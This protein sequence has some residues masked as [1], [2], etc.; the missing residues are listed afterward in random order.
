MSFFLVKRK[1]FD[2][3]IGMKIIV[4]HKAPDLDAISSSWIIKKFLP[5]WEDARLE[6]VYAG[7]KLEGNYTKT[8]GA[9]EEIDGEEVIH[10]DTGLTPLD[11]HQTQDMN[12]C[13]ASLALDFV[14]E[15]NPDLL[16]H[17][18][19]PE[20]LRRLVDLIVDTDHFQDVYYPDSDS[21][22]YDLTI[23]SIIDGFKMEYPQD[24]MACA[25]F[26]MECLDKLLLVFESRVATE[27]DLKEHAISFDTK[28]GKGMAIES[29]FDEV[30]KLAQIQGYA[31]VVRKDPNE[32]FIRIKSRPAPREK[33]FATDSELKEARIDLTPV[34]EEIKKQDKTGTWFL[35]VSKKMLLN[36][37]SKNP[38]SVASPL[39]LEQI[40]EILKKTLV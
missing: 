11:H 39:S 8:G 21:Y 16:H 20:A 25:Q 12:V 34:Y 31:V 29:V 36:G 14:F 10:V 28:Y 22:R 13:A 17:E 5:G 24:D 6:F 4:T 2:I 9:I 37:S 23:E 26:G 30:L 38:S 19:K 40:I 33:Y 7:E 27:R 35:H 3:L 32:G 1:Q 15:H 18:V